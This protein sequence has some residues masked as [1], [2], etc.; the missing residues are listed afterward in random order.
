MANG[1]AISAAIL[2]KVAAGANVAEAV[3]AVLG[4]GTYVKMAG[5]LYDTL[6]AKQ[7]A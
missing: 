5:D 6:R 3:D 4:A 2:A 7:Q 1:K